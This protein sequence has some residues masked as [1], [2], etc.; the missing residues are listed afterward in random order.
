MLIVS[1]SSL[2][3]STSGWIEQLASAMVWSDSFHCQSQEI[4]CCNSLSQAAAAAAT[5]TLLRVV[6]FFLRGG[7]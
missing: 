3:V 7:E 4:L 5:G 2:I 6:V 1:A